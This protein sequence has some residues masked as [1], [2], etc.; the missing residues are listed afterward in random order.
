[1]PK[2]KIRLFSDEQY[3]KAAR[4]IYGD[5][6]PQNLTEEDIDAHFSLYL[7]AVKKKDFY[8]QNNMF[9]DEVKQCAEDYLKDM[10]AHSILPPKK[11]NKKTA[12]K[13]A[14]NQKW[15]SELIRQ[16]IYQNY[17][18]SSARGWFKD[19]QK[20]MESLLNPEPEK[21]TG[22][23]FMEKLIY[24]QSKFFFNKLPDYV[25]E[26]EDFQKAEQTEEM[27]NA[28]KFYDFFRMFYLPMEKLSDPKT[29]LEDKAFYKSLGEMDTYTRV[30]DASVQDIVSGKYSKEEKA[31]RENYENIE[32]GF[33]R[34]FKGMN[35]EHCRRILSTP[36][37]K[38]NNENDSEVYQ[39]CIFS[40]AE[41][42][43]AFKKS[44]YKKCMDAINERHEKKV[45]EIE[46]FTNLTA[47]YIRGL[48]SIGIKDEVFDLC[49]NDEK[50][51]YSEQGISGIVKALDAYPEDA[52]NGAKIYDS[53]NADLIRH[54][55]KYQN[56]P[57]LK[58]LR[59]G[60]AD[61]IMQYRVSIPSEGIGNDDLRTAY[62]KIAEKY[63]CKKL[64]NGEKDADILKSFAIGLMMRNGVEITYVPLQLAFDNKNRIKQKIGEPLPV[65]NDGSL[66][67][68][69]RGFKIAQ[70]L[71][72]ENDDWIQIEQPAQ[73]KAI[74]D[75]WVVI[76][77]EEAAE[78]EART[79]AIET[80]RLKENKSLRDDLA[81]PLA[82]LEAQ[83]PKLKEDELRNFTNLKEFVKQLSEC[84]ANKNF[85]DDE[86]IDKMFAL[87]NF[88]EKVPDCKG[89]KNK[90]ANDAKTAILLVINKHFKKQ[91]NLDAITRFEEAE[92]RKQLEALNEVDLEQ[93]I[94][95][96]HAE[97]YYQPKD[98]D[99]KYAH[100]KLVE[101]RELIDKCEAG[102][103]KSKR[104]FLERKEELETAVAERIVAAAFAA[105][106]LS[107]GAGHNDIQEDNVN[108]TKEEKEAWDKKFRSD[109][110]A[111]RS[112]PDFQRMMNEV[113]DV[114][115]FDRLKEIAKDRG[116]LLNELSK[117]TK[118]V[119]KR[120]PKEEA[121]AAVKNENAPKQ[122][123]EIKKNN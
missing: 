37:E 60:S 53:L 22:F 64:E 3:Q 30:R 70:A 96:A 24:G 27:Q 120:M 122:K 86:R 88:A 47:S 31:I 119:K 56:T 14:E 57:A 68:I 71:K 123:N 15:H 40:L 19:G 45:Q 4:L 97:D 6:I 80:A 5:K 55:N 35:H 101:T 102:D 21:R 50:K 87:R 41:N 18:M 89:K 83:L 65:Q 78:K 39:D 103:G 32:Q 43:P 7:T 121:P 115:S 44:G 100:D 58:T 114:K 66:L 42:A 104:T 17:N 117:H 81:A 75:D 99:Q 108:L 118:V 25:K 110:E 38:L 113:Y 91:V 11:L 112:R 28:R 109:V 98:A 23:G 10:E 67:E 76:E 84:C 69:Y 82:A 73:K 29:S 72:K 79:D 77:A 54:E 93:R 1:M 59:Q 94:P 51:P 9:E 63:D 13:L 111:V 49:Y 36:I 2:N 16:G 12:A 48:S 26:N 8:G 92:D 74:E 85:S 116:K 33:S 105:T 20:K 95:R 34:G 61:N 90:A 106:S 52:V 62:N 46:S 107:R